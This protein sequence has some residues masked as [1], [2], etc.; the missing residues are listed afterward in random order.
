MLG[1]MLRES[2][3]IGERTEQRAGG[4]DWRGPTFAM[5]L[6]VVVRQA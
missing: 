2:P 6:R 4:I 5:S 1:G 3:G